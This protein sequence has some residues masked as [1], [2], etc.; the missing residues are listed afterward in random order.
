LGGKSPVI[1]DASADPALA[2]R[3]VLLGRFVNAGQT[4]VSPDYVLVAKD[5]I[6]LCGVFNV[7]GGFVD[8]GVGS[9]DFLVELVNVA[10]VLVCIAGGMHNYQACRLALIHAK[11]ALVSCNTEGEGDVGETSEGGS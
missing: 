6:L 5:R 3:R 9:G 8:L 7:E 4:C 10:D 1:V 2:A 11:S